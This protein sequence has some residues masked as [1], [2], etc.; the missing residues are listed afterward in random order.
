MDRSSPGPTLREA[1]WAFPADGAAAIGGALMRFLESLPTRPRLLGLGEPMH[2][3]EAFPQLRNKAFQHLVAH[4]GYRSIAIETDCLAA[5][6]VDAF[7]A[8]GKGE[9]D[10]V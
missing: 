10:E 3:V 9:L 7:V 8:D 6:T 1:G 2:G 5:L 4:D